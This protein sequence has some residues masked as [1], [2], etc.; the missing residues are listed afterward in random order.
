[1]QLATAGWEWTVVSAFAAKELPLLVPLVQAAMNAT[2]ATFAAM[3]ELELAVTVATTAE[4]LMKDKIDFSWETLAQQICPHGVVAAYA[5]V[6]GRLVQLCGGGKGSPLV[7]F[8]HSFQKQHAPSMILGKDFIK[9]ITDLKL[10]PDSLTPMVRIAALIA[11]LCAP[12]HRCQDGITRLLVKSDIEKWKSK[13]LLHA[14]LDLEETLCKAWKHMGPCDGNQKV[15][16]FGKLCIR[17]VLSVLQ[18]GKQGPESKDYTIEDA[19]DCFHQDLKTSLGSPDAKPATVSSPKEKLLQE[20][21]SLEDSYDPLYLAKL[22]IDLELGKMYTLKQCPGELFA[23]A[24]KFG[25]I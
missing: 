7:H 10:A 19:L 4:Q 18:K 23:L 25:C 20:P 12:E 5:P 11:N 13:K 3:T 6:V 15:K 9:A 17:S 1:M 14:V 24:K 2:N 16:A 21:V 22:N 8:L